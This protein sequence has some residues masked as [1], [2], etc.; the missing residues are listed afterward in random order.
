MGVDANGPCAAWFAKRRAPYRACRSLAMRR[1]LRQLFPPAP[2]AANLPQSTQG[3]MP[4]IRAVGRWRG[5]SPAM[6]RT[7]LERAGLLSLRSAAP[8]SYRRVLAVPTHEELTARH[9]ATLSAFVIRARR[10]AE[11]SL[12]TSSPVDYE[13]AYHRRVTLDVA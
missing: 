12:H 8:P 11:H 6:G 7:A 3:L 13:H 1:V 5:R 10:V 2:P 9:A 4:R